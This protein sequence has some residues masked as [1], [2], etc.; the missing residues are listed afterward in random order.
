MLMHPPNLI[1]WIFKNKR[2][3]VVINNYMRPQACSSPPSHSNSKNGAVEERRA[4]LNEVSRILNLSYMLASSLL[5]PVGLLLL[6][7]IRPLFLNPWTS[8][9]SEWKATWGEKGVGNKRS[10][11]LCRGSSFAGRVRAESGEFGALLGEG[12]PCFC[13][14]VT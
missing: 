8:D 6:C 10:V 11:M 13:S 4:Q 7:P 14:Q 5:P 3:T 9:S 12:C 2:K 1:S